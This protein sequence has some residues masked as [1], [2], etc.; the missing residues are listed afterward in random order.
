MPAKQSPFM[1]KGHF[2]R[3]H[4]RMQMAAVLIERTL[5]DVHVKQENFSCP[6]NYI[7]HAN[8]AIQPS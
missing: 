6:E 2:E 8:V 7:E 1:R 3:S 4:S 5:N